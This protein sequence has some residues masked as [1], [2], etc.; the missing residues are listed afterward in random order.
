MRAIK[1]YLD[2]PYRL[3]NAVLSVVELKVGVFYDFFM[4]IVEFIVLQSYLLTCFLVKTP[5]LSAK[6]RNW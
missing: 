2:K 5:I 4:K 3:K 1:K 6:K